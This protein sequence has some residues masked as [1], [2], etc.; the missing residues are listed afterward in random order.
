MNF[1]FCC[2][3][4]LCFSYICFMIYKHTFLVLIAILLHC[5]VSYNIM[6]KWDLGNFAGLREDFKE[7]EQRKKNKHIKRIRK[8]HP[9]NW[10]MLYSKLLGHYSWLLQLII[11]NSFCNPVFLIRFFMIQ[12]FFFFFQLEFLSTRFA[13]EKTFK[14][15]YIRKINLLHKR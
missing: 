4:S 3:C 6:M 12:L 15:K 9:I 5:L 11:L 1:G 2:F 10:L 14:N 7:L 13:F 8:K